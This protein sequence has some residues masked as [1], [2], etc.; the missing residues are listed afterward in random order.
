MVLT[1][2]LNLFIQKVFLKLS[3]NCR[4]EG[5]DV[6]VHDDYIFIGY[7]N[8]EDFKKFKVSRTNLHAVNNISDFFF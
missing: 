7:S 5:G 1:I 8:E 6:I 2:S 3:D 4:I